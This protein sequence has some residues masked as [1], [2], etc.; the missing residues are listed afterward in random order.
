MKKVKDFGV[1]Y[2]TSPV[3]HNKNAGWLKKVEKDL[4]NITKQED[5]II[6]INNV[7]KQLRKMKNWEA[8][9]PDGLQ[10][11]W[12]KRFVSCHERVTEQLQ[13]SLK[14]ND[15]P[16]WLT[17]GRTTLIIKDKAKGNDVANFSPITCLPLMWKLFTG[18][19]GDEVYEHLERE[20]LLPKE[21]KAVL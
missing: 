20:N 12:I 7:K 14:M 6:S 15:T 11:F 19:L 3:L 4:E 18:I 16:D 9:S 13:G 21:Q 1:K 5:I 2:G 8:P 17:R 10:G